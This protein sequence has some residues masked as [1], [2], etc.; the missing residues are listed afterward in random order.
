MTDFEKFIKDAPNIE[1]DIPVEFKIWIN[2]KIG[3]IKYST[4]HQGYEGK[5]NVFSKAAE[6]IQ[7]MFQISEFLA[8]KYVG[9]NI[10]GYVKKRLGLVDEEDEEKPEA[11]DMSFLRD[12]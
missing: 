9:L 4:S 6:Q 1:F 5:A 11:G 12:W 10:S 7:N 2:K 3:Y 8:K